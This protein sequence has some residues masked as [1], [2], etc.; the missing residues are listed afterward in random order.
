MDSDASK[1]GTHIDVSNTKISWGNL[2][3]GL[4]IMIAL[5]AVI[6]F[7]ASGRLDWKFGWFYVGLTAVFTI[8]SRIIMVYKTPDLIA[9]RGG[10]LQKENIKPW[11]K[12]IMPLTLIAPTIMLIV[13]GLD[14]RFTWSPKLPLSIHVT[15][16][17]FAAAGYFLSSWATVVNRFFSA[18]V[19]IQTERGHTV[20][21][22]GPYQY[23]RHPG[24]AGGVMSSIAAP[25]FLGSLWALVPAILVIILMVIRTGLEDTTLMEELI[26]YREYA[27][28]VRHRLIPGVW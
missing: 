14:A 25:L 7:G 20:I 15:G 1:N 24:Y 22:S 3:I 27:I 21:S 23:I 19:R 5:P 16:I 8:G 10:S 17:I 11:D 18:S 6:L 12:V 28:S 4:G 2:I 26:G 9:E 13:A